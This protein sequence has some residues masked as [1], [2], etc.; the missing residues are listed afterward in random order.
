MN[1]GIVVRGQA[2]MAELESAVEEGG[3]PER[4][5][6]AAAAAAAVAAA[7]AAAAAAT[8]Q[9]LQVTGQGAETCVPTQCPLC[10]VQLN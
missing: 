5:P 3:N 6:G 1:G 9:M 8:N 4:A 2:K 7:A 10:N